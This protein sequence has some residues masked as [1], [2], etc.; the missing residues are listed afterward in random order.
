MSR[1]QHQLTEADL[2]GQ[3]VLIILTYHYS[4]RYAIN[5][6]I[7]SITIASICSLILCTDVISVRSLSKLIRN[8]VLANRRACLDLRPC[9][10]FQDNRKRI[11]RYGIPSDL[12]HMGKHLWQLAVRIFRV[13]LF[14]DIIIKLT[15][16]SI[17]LLSSTQPGRSLFSAKLSPPQLPHFWRG[18]I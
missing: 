12:C 9:S 6:N 1:H 15:L 4:S 7:L 2:I 13:Q 3:P 8:S 16:R 11:S 18:K 5:A 17:V 10:D 14:I